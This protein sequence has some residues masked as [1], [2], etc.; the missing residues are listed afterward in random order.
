MSDINN[1]TILTAIQSKPTNTILH[2]NTTE[3]NIPVYDEIDIKLPEFFD[4]RKTWSGLIIPSVNQGKCGS[5]WAFASS[6][7]LADRFNIQSMG[8]M[9]VELS[10]VRMIICNFISDPEYS[11]LLTTTSS[12][13]MIDSNVKALRETACFGNTL[14]EAWNYLYIWGTNTKS[15]AP[16]DE[17]ANFVGVANIPLCTAI[18]GLTG[19]MCSDFTY[20]EKTGIETG[21]PARYYRCKHYYTIPNSVQLENNQENIK[22]TIYK[23]GPVTA[24]FEIYPNFY[25]FNPETEIY[26]WDGKG[27]IISG[28]AIE[29]LGWGE[30]DSIPYWIIK[31]FWGT[32]WGMNGYF[33]MV[34]GI[35]DCKIEDNVVCGVPDFFYPSNYE[36][37]FLNLGNISEGNVSSLRRYLVDNEVDLINGGLDSETGYTRRVLRSKPWLKKSRP[38][39]LKN[40]PNFNNWI[41]GRDAS[42]QN[43]IF[44][45]EEL[46]DNSNCETKNKNTMYITLFIFILLTVILFIAFFYRRTKTRKYRKV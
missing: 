20:L 3:S 37:N 2:S 8:Q 40:L 39:K 36:P 38:V 34:R 33:Y 43:R 6:S 29:I 42:V 7:C 35:N 16:Y 24:S 44:Y 32:D 28:H 1:Q 22:Y 13:S 4:G 26:K 18:F 46:R 27:E 19:D 9:H 5:C 25:T 15:C 10:P 41:A 14:V 31:N 12:E 11:S 23:Y 21:T 30:R 45:S 17:I